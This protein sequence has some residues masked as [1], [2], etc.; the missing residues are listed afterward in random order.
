MATAI[1]DLSTQRGYDPRDFTLI[2]AGGAGPVHGASVAQETEISQVLIPKGAGSFCAFGWLLS[3]I[4]HDFVRSGLC[5]SI[6]QTMP[7]YRTMDGLYRE[8]LNEAQGFGLDVKKAII[9][10]SIDMR[11]AGQFRTVEVDLPNG[12]GQS[13]STQHL[14]ETIKAFDEKHKNLYSFNM[15]GRAVELINFRTKVFISL[16]KPELEKQKLAKSKASSALV[17]RRNCFF[18]NGFVETG[19]YDGEKLLPGFSIKG[20]AVIELVTTTVVIPPEYTC[21]VNE[22]GDYLL[23]YRSKPIKAV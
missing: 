5:T 3:D 18:G 6:N 14:A 8:M 2:A 9:K 22:F 23:K 20:P 17:G 13:L 12:Q 19:I 11:Y 21:A 15:P 16:P 4:R 7:I 10:R 1:R